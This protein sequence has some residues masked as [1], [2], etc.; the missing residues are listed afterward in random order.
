MKPLETMLLA[1]RDGAAMLG[2]SRATFWRRVADGTLPRPIRLGGVT[3]WRQDEL[4]LAI[5]RASAI[6]DAAAQR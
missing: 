1:D 5:E 6:R 2:I 3:R 4:L